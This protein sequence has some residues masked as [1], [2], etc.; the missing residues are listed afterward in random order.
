M[1]ALG[2]FIIEVL[3]CFAISLSLIFLLRPLLR[4][5]LVDI[6]GTDQRAAFWLMFS[7][8]MLVISPLLIVIYFA[9]TQSDVS[10]NIAEAIKDTLFRSLLGDFIALAMLGQVIWKSIGLESM[11]NS[12]EHLCE[13]SILSAQPNGEQPK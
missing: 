5:V 11:A 4:A 9:P 13:D 12:A 3:L 8:L 1:N 10:I 7:Q 6:C 2:L